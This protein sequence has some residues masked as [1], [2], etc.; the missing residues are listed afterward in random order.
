LNIWTRLTPREKEVEGLLIT[1][2]IMTSETDDFSF[3]VFLPKVKSNSDLLD[4]TA[5]NK[6]PSGSK[7]PVE[8]KNWLHRIDPLNMFFYGM[9][10]GII[11]TLIGAFIASFLLL[12]YGA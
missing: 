8:E 3:S 1:S 4:P 12:R 2:A 7:F 6:V 5:P 11:A 9:I 10:A